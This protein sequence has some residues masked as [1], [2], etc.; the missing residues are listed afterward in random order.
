ML[1]RK[2][3]DR[4]RKERLAA[5]KAA[6]GTPEVAGRLFGVAGTA[7]ADRKD[8]GRITTP[9]KKKRVASSAAAG[10]RKPGAQGQ[11]REV[12]APYAEEPA[13]S[14][15]D[16]CHQVVH[17]TVGLSVEDAPRQAGQRAAGGQGGESVHPDQHIEAA[18]STRSGPNIP[19]ST[20]ASSAVRSS[21]DGAASAR[22]GAATGTCAAAADLSP[23]ASGSGAGADFGARVGA[24]SGAGADEFPHREERHIEPTGFVQANAHVAETDLA[25]QVPPGRSLRSGP[26]GSRAHLLERG[27]GNGVHQRLTI[28]EVPIRG[29]RGHAR[30]AGGL[31]QH[32]C[33]APPPGPDRDRRRPKRGGD[34]RGDRCPLPEPYREVYGVDIPTGDRLTASLRQRT[35]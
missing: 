15:R 24:G 4:L 13:A 32:D 30:Y 27:P 33:L 7:D 16:P 17:Q 22:S 2:S 31:P 29:P 19:A 10:A 35:R 11:P 25:Q 34:H 18:G 9:A 12:V 8:D 3:S 21:R 28:G 23:F 26:R 6:K 20:S 1:A 5:A 14:A